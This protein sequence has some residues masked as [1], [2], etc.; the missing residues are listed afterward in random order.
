[1]RMNQIALT[2]AT[3]RPWPCKAPLP[4]LQ[5]LLSS[6]LAWVRKAFVA[7]DIKECRAR[8]KFLFFATGFSSKLKCF[9][10]LKAA[11][12]SRSCKRRSVRHRV[13]GTQHVPD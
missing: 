5:V 7:E 8:L 2:S 4:E 12:T 1:M 6:R 3:V 9:N 13:V 10:I 11:S